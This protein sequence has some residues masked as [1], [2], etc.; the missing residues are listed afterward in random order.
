[1]FSTFLPHLPRSWRVGKGQ[2]EGNLPLGQ[3]PP[4]R[5]C[6]CFWSGVLGSLAPSR[7]RAPLGSWHVSELYICLSPRSTLPWGFWEASTKPGFVGSHSGLAFQ[8][9]ALPSSHTGENMMEAHGMVVWSDWF[10]LRS[11]REAGHGGKLGVEPFLPSLLSLFSI[12]ILGVQFLK[13]R[14]WGWGSDVLFPL[15]VW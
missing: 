7:P 14:Y 11:I 4:L 9:C 3:S 15:C 2:L 6:H 8:D 13:L 5:A 10:G 1:M 12:R